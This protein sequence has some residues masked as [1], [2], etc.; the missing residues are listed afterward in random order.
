MPSFIFYKKDSDNQ[1]QL[2]GASLLV[3]SKDLYLNLGLSIREIQMGQ[4]YKVTNKGTS[5][6]CLP[7]PP[8]NWNKP[9]KQNP[10]PPNADNEYP[11]LKVTASQV[12]IIQEPTGKTVAL[13][14]CL[15][16]DQLQLTHLR[17]VEGVN[18]LFV[19]YPND[20]SYK[21]DEYKCVYYPV[22]RA[23]RD[24]IEEVLLAQYKELT[25]RG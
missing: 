4:M 2:K 3:A 24:H 11:C 8:E 23:L 20:S 16:N 17:I 9:K 13:A 18:G 25:K 10:N 6:T 5:I 12:F 14:R 22:T 1:L 21:S 15:L 7:I 19:S